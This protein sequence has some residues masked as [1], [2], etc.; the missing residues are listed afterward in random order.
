MQNNPD[1]KYKIAFSRRRTLSIAVSPDKG[2]VVKAPLR[3]P[4]RTVERFVHEKSGWIVKTLNGF[5]S[6]KRIDKLNGY[7][8]GD[9][10]LL[11]GRE[12][13][14]KL[15]QSG[16]DSVRLGNNDTIEAT[17]SKNNNPLIIRALLEDWFKFVAREKL[18]NKFREALVKYGDHG[19]PPSGFNVK[20]MKKRWG[21]CSSKN[22]IAISYDLI[23]L[24]EM[25]SEYVI[26]HELCH[27]KHHNHG[28]G[29]YKLLS[30][31]YP[32]WKKVREGL[33]KYLR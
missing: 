23:R 21:S 31:A 16:N 27:L 22:K 1:F 12:H 6:L 28:T 13:K 14:L 10:V 30:E 25:Y 11:F 24:D 33:K 9:S 18:T 29:F 32:D 26:I 4:I 5:K 2:V 20:T 19:F 17:F 3:T 7:S 8:D 15:S